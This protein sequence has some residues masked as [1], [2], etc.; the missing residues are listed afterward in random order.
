MADLTV[1]LANTGNGQ[2]IPIA[3]EALDIP[4]TIHYVNIAKDEQFA[5]DFSKISPNNKIP[6]IVDSFPADGKGFLSIFE[7]AAILQYI[8]YTKA[9]QLG[10]STHL[11]PADDIRVKAHTDQWL[12]FQIASL[13]P[14]N[15]QWNHFKGLSEPNP[16]GV[17]R[18]ETEVHRIFGV[19]ERRLS[20]VDYFNG[21]GYSIADIAIYPNVKFTLGRNPNFQA[22][23]PAVGRW[24]E[25]VNGQK[26]A[27]EGIQKAADAAA[28]AAK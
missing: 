12:Y 17:Q 4:Y 14:M 7:S 20:E 18:Y 27:L 9:K 3:L 2:K 16:Y 11:Y 26:G 25:R 24:L 10:K 28:A 6:A 13:G 8:A 15:G 19:M 23:Y 21:H 22:K 5:P 1:Y